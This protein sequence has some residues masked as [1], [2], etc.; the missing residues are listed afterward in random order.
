[1][2][3]KGSVFVLRTRRYC[4]EIIP[5]ITDISA[6]FRSEPYA[7]HTAIIAFLHNQRPGEMR[8]DTFFSA[9]KKSLHGRVIIAPRPSYNHNSAGL[10]NFGLKNFSLSMMMPDFTSRFFIDDNKMSNLISK[11][12]RRRMRVQQS[13][14]V[15][16]DR[17]EQ[18]RM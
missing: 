15:R 11:L 14:Q 17:D 6:K 16:C 9:E 7:I 18:G 10:K 4:A 8:T 2:F 12:F 5:K 13:C 1:M 3:Y